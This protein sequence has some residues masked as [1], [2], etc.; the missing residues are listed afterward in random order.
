MN[1][2]SPLA[3]KTLF[4]RS[5]AILIAVSFA[6][7]IFRATKENYGSLI[8][9]IVAAMAVCVLTLGLLSLLALGFITLVTN[10]PSPRPSSALSV[11]SR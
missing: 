5:L 7:A 8:G 10:T 3:S 11:D 1:H 6:R 9:L 4:R 2:H